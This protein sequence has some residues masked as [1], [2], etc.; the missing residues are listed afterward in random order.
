MQTGDKIAVRAYKSD[1]TCYRWWTVTV[2][3]VDENEIVVTAP[4]HHRVESIDGGWTSRYAIRSYYWPDKWYS[5]LEV[6]TPDGKLNE[7]YV[8]INS[9]IV[10]RGGNITFTDFELDVS[11]KLPRQ[12]R[13]VDEDE[14]LEA[15]SRYGYSKAF[16]QTCYQV[17][18]DVIEVANRW[19]AKGMPR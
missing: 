2:E 7:I 13:M 4:P 19:T 6:Y 15:A 8:N 10:I 9:P 17:A 12:A 14:F 5:L 1:G 3:A 16:Q 11:R 18:R